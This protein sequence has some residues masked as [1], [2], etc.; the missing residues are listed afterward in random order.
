A[1]LRMLGGTRPTYVGRVPRTGVEPGVR[2][3]GTHGSRL[4]TRP[5][6]RSDPPGAE[7]DPQ[8]W[9]GARPRH[10]LH[11]ADARAGH[12]GPADGARLLHQPRRSEGAHRDVARAAAGDRLL[13]A[14]DRRAAAAP[15]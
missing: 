1:W 5:R 9:R 15:P 12:P 11:H 13:P 8:P 3:P 4:S 7:R 10:R 2:G 6:R 14:P